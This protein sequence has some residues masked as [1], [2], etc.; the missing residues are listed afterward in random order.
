MYSQFT[1][2]TPL[3]KITVTLPSSP[4]PCSKASTALI[5]WFFALQPSAQTVYESP[6]EIPQLS[7]ASGAKKKHTNLEVRQQLTTPGSHLERL[8]DVVACSTRGAANHA[9]RRAR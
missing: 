8:E 4:G 5:V 1:K 3:K 6:N 2:E 9:A 7:R